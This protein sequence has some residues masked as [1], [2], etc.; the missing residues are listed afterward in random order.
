M[1]VGVVSQYIVLGHDAYRIC[2]EISPY[3]LIPNVHP[4]HPKIS[5]FWKWWK[6]QPLLRYHGKMQIKQ[7]FFYNFVQGHLNAIKPT[8]VIEEKNWILYVKQTLINGWSISYFLA[9][10]GHVSI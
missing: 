4:Q 3:R 10:F 7:F 9:C 8:H 5:V 1:N 6:S 2:I